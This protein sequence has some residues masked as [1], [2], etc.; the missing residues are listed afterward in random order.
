[1]SLSFTNMKDIQPY[2]TTI[3]CIARSS[4][5]LPQGFTFLSDNAQWCRLLGRAK[6]RKRGKQPCWQAL[7]KA[8]GCRH[9]THRSQARWPTPPPR[10]Q[11]LCRPRPSTL[12][13]SPPRGA[14][15]Q[16]HPCVALAFPVAGRRRPRPPAP[17]R[18]C[19]PRLAT[20]LC[21]G[22][23]PCWAHRGCG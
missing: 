15:R 7:R 11:R 19:T 12:P 22:L 17:L 14:P 2:L 5:W 10:R 9:P 4:M 20:H 6:P 18:P 1:M 8:S 3:S 16:S 13:T 21:L 23:S